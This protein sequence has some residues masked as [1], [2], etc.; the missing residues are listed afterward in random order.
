MYPQY[1]A[2]IGMVAK[3]SNDSPVTNT[4]TA[5]IHCVGTIGAMKPIRMLHSAPLRRN[6]FLSADRK[7]E[8]KRETYLIGPGMK[9][10]CQFKRR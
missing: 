10:R 3:S 1:E 7:A 5:M 2:P 4:P 9:W 6:P 8:N